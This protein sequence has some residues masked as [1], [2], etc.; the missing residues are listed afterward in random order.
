MR[1]QSVRTRRLLGLPTVSFVEE[2]KISDHGD[3][4]VTKQLLANTA[5][6]LFCVQLLYEQQLNLFTC[7]CAVKHASVRSCVTVARDFLSES[8]QVF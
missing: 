1:P 8:F 7:M 5:K 6:A 3:F 4:Q 2:L